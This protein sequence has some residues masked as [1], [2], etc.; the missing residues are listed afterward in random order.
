MQETTTLVYRSM[1]PL[2][3]IS[4]VFMTFFLYFA[5]TWSSRQKTPEVIARLHDSFIGVF[6]VAF[7]YWF[8]EPGVKFFIKLKFTPNRITTISILFSLITGYL[9]AIGKFAPAGWMLILTGTMD[10]FDGRV[11]RQTNNSTISGGF[12][13]SCTD[14]YTDGFIFGGVALYFASDLFRTVNTPVNFFVPNIDFIMLIVMIIMLVGTASVS[15]SKAKGESLGFPTNRGLMQRPERI[16]V[17]AIISCTHPFVSVMLKKVNA[18]PDLVFM[19]A[20]ALMAIMI[21][22]SALSRMRSIFADIVKSEK[23]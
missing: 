10:L 14:R 21:N 18:H 17:L 7:W 3:I 8:T 6:F 13:D 15:Y 4:E 11:A 2:I 22:G 9:Y 1:L 5:I 20:L 19:I 16:T 23:A 12:F